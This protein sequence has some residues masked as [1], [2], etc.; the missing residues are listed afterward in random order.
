M[1]TLRHLTSQVGLNDRVQV[2]IR[3]LGGIE[4]CVQ[5]LKRTRCWP[6]VKAGCGLVRNLVHHL[7]NH[8]ILVDLNIIIRLG[9]IIVLAVKENRKRAKKLS[10]RQQAPPSTPLKRRAVSYTH[11][12]L[13]TTPYV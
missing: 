11:L 7:E 13:P 12:T 9:E 4:L 2:E 8:E 1:C 6:I 5:I 10:Q 3:H